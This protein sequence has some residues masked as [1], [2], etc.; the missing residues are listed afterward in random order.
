M[1]SVSF[2]HCSIKTFSHSFLIA[3]H[4]VSSLENILPE[5]FHFF[6]PKSQL[7]LNLELDKVQISNFW[8]PQHHIH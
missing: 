1:L 8:M 4:N 2:L 6:T 3:S 5:N 7:D